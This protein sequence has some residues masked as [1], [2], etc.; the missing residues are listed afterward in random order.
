MKW[1]SP[2][3]L[4]TEGMQKEQ[5]KVSHANLDDKFD[6]E[7]VGQPACLDGEGKDPDDNGKD[8]SKG[9]EIEGCGDGRS[10]DSQL[11]DLQILSK[12]LF[13]NDVIS[14]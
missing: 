7:S 14:P 12:S 6:E 2:L 5:E 9:D 13:K 4:S 11:D 3:N 10:H 8:E 1:A